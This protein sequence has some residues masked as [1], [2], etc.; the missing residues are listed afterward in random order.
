M[1]LE[2][3][4]VWSRVEPEVL[5]AQWS[6]H[7]GEGAA[8]APTLHADAKELGREQTTLPSFASR[9]SLDATG[10]GERW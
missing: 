3:V 5:L 1:R 6:R 4:V 2:S 9:M 7:E 8:P 10:V